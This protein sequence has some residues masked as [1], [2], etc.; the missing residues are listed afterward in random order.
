[1]D[2]DPGK[3]NT[4]TTEEFPLQTSAPF[5]REIEFEGRINPPSKIEPED[6]LITY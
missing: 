4:N 5:R 6:G 2:E 1:M 3:V